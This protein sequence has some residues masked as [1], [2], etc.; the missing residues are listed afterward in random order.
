MLELF[1]VVVHIVVLRQ[2]TRHR[3]IDPGA[4]LEVARRAIEAIDRYTDALARW[5]SD[6]HLSPSHTL[7]LEFPGKAVAHD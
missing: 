6:G 7:V 1:V 4:V 5:L 2:A 3:N